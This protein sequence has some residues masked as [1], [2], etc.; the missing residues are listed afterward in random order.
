MQ[1]LCIERVTLCPLTAI[2]EPQALDAVVD[3]WNR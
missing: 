3:L 1:V 2:A